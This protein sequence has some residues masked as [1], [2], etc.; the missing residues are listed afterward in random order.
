MKNK[1]HLT[2]EQRYEIE[3]LLGQEDE[4]GGLLQFCN[5]LFILCYCIIVK[6]LCLYKKIVLLAITDMMAA[7]CAGKQE[8]FANE[9]IGA[10]TISNATFSTSEIVSSCY[11][12]P[13]LPYSF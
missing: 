9:A 4:I 12:I 7:F 5:A 2:R 13:L 10:T 11:L 8:T 6:K 1:K 3:V